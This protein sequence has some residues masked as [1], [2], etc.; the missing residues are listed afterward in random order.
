MNAA[1]ELARTIRYLPLMTAFA[2]VLDS[3]DHLPLA[4]QEALLETLSRRVAEQRRAELI[5]T[6]KEARAEFAAG[7]CKPATP[8]AILKKI[9]G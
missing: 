3:A 7:T 2:K 9:V 5:S 8:V 6:I 4:E 1:I